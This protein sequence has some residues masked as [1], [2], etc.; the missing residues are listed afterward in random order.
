[1]NP[2]TLTFEFPSAHAAARFCA[3]VSGS[4]APSHRVVDIPVAHEAEAEAIRAAA[5]QWGGLDETSVYQRLLA[6]GCTLDH[7]ESDL[8]VKATDEAR[9]II[10]SLPCVRATARTFTS[11]IDGTLWFDLPFMYDPFWQARRSR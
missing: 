6:A 2:C 10:A 7:H 5:A 9:R 11:Q 3:A 8:Y 4:L 1:M